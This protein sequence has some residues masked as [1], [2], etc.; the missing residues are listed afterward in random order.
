MK[1]FYKSF[2]RVLFSMSRKR[3]CTLY[4]S[5]VIVLLGVVVAVMSFLLIDFSV[6]SLVLGSF[7][8]G[9]SDKDAIDNKGLIKSE[10]ILENKVRHVSNISIDLNKLILSEDVLV[11][12]EKEH[13][14]LKKPLSREEL[15]LKLNSHE[16]VFKGR[17]PLDI[18]ISYIE[19]FGKFK[20]AGK[21]RITSRSKLES[22]SIFVSGAHKDF[23]WYACFF[24]GIGT[25]YSDLSLRR[26]DIDNLTYE[27]LIED[28]S[29][30]DIVINRLERDGLLDY[31]LR[32][33]ALDYCELKGWVMGI[34][35]IANLS[36]SRLYGLLNVTFDVEQYQSDFGI[37]WQ[38]VPEHVI[39]QSTDTYGL[40]LR[41]AI[42]DALIKYIGINK[43]IFFMRIFTSSRLTIQL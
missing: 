3:T 41:S 36:E 16:N 18:V 24:E 21:S 1:K 25:W 39:K 33:Q 38:L 31:R 19:R 10:F 14:R 15:I 29:G 30:L 23:L 8:G 11:K 40:K 6:I 17:D 9:D 7:I 26:E 28:S 5:L 4:L 12:A 13:N 35:D 43:N 22:I 32:G 34:K 20:F 2:S 27:L 42:Y 37:K